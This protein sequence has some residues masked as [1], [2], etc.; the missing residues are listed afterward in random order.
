[1]IVAV[2]IHK[3]QVTGVKPPVNHNL[4]CLSFIFVIP[5]HY[6]RTLNGNFTYAVFIRIY[7]FRLY[8]YKRFSD[9]IY[10]R[11]VIVITYNNRRTLGQTVTYNYRY[12]IGCKILCS[13][14]LKCSS[15]AYNKSQSAAKKAV[16]F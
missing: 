3:T 11:R 15:T 1:M 6:H 4:V 8:P 10:C 12:T 9:C 16:N 14:L 13:L 2:F 5:F 7:N